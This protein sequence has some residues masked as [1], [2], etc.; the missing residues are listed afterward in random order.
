MDIFLL[1]LRILDRILE[2]KIITLSQIL[3]ITE[4]QH[5]VL[6]A[7]FCDDYC[8]SLFNGMNKEK[9]KL[10]DTVNE[11]D[12]VFEKTY[13]RISPV[14]EDEA[15][16]HAGPLIRMQENIKKA[17]ALDVRIRVQEARNHAS[18]PTQ[19]KTPDNKTIRKKIARIYE[20]NKTLSKQPPG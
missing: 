14:F 12:R 13:R 15:P 5:A 6:S 10:I 1:H 18:R 16:G 11:Y 2:K 4:N 9:Q 19:K 8:L 17:T 3:N 7:G 20:K